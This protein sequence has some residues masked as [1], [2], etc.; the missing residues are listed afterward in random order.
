[1]RYPLLALALLSI[2]LSPALAQTSLPSD[3]TILNI[4]ATEHGEVAQDTLTASLGIEKQ[5]SEPRGLQAQINNL[6]AQAVA[7]A[8]TVQGVEVST[9]QYN[10]YPVDPDPNAP[11]PASKVKAA[12]TW[13]GSQSLTLKSTNAD[14]LLSVAGG[15]QDIG[16][17]MQ[18]LSYGV[19]PQKDE[20]AR[21]SLMEA[22]LTKLRAKAA[23]AARA[24][25]KTKIDFAEINVD[26]AP[27]PVMRPMRTM[28]MMAKS[29]EPMPAP[30][31]EAGTTDIDL[32]V[33]AKVI[34]K[35]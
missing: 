19:S 2:S 17:N 35:P 23:R 26:S 4:S 12:R 18:D 1:M 33:N 7:K 8:K 31:A 15:L 28:A 13:R 6:M 32:T 27:L 34:L 22:A 11:S 3:E 25:G 5:A 16:L 20:D 24:L 10:V 14:A 29:A 30:T 21:D 9:G